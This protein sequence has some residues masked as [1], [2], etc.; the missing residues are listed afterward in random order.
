MSAPPKVYNILF[1]GET[2]SG[3]STLIEHLKKYADPNYVVKKENIGDS[4]FSLTKDV[5]SFPIQTNTPAYFITSLKTKDRVDYGRFIEEVDQEDYEDKL[6]DRKYKLEQESSDALKVTFNLID[7]PGLNDTS[8]FDEANIAIIFKALTSIESVNLV[9]IT[10]SNNPFTD[11]LMA[12][13]KAYVDLLPEFNG[14]I[15]FVH[16]K[17]DYAKLHPQDDTSFAESLK[18]KKRILAELVGRDSVPHILI[19]N[20][21]GTK[22]VVRD[23]ITKNTLRNLLSMAKLNQPVPIRTMRMNKTEK[24]RN[25]DLILR[26]KYEA[27]VKARLE[28][29]GAKDQKQQNLMG[30]INETKGLITK[31]EVHLKAAKEYLRV[32]DNDSLEL[33][34]EELYQQ[35]F[36]ILN[37][38]EGAKP[39]YYPGKKRALEPG[40]MHHILDHLD[41]RT[42]NIKVLQEAGGKG[43]AFWAVKFRR[44]KRQNGIYHV[45]IYITRRKKFAEVIEQKKTEVRTCEGLLEDYNTDLEA[46]ERDNREQQIEIKE[47][48]DDLKQDLYLLNRTAA[49]QLD[50]QIFHSLVEAAVYVRD[51]G[52]SALN[53]EKFYVE[54][55][56]QLE[57][58]DKNTHEFVVAPPVNTSDNFDDAGSD[59]G[60]GLDISHT[61]FESI[62]KSVSSDANDAL[63][64]LEKLKLQD[65]DNK[66]TKDATL[67]C[68]EP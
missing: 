27:S 29:L 60:D 28:T 53:V 8:L 43:E 26:D 24:M 54:R 17:T 3:K 56:E 65:K 5:L 42:Q 52:Q 68:P 50:N 21:I 23:C 44:R 51:L 41:I 1:L 46:L 33:L 11:G 38:M 45:K 59:I 37:M 6:N 7:T 34:H 48:L 36:S 32:N 62:V 30:R 19:D 20:A 22:Q 31:K 67:S 66:D 35:D 25:V 13:L 10:V 49:I 18:E 55:R 4:I 58:L 14:N 63:A 57:A 16:T 40:F 12:A 9:A 15:V 2:Q 47:L 64:N 61:E 39:L